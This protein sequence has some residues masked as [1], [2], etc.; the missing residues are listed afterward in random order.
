MLILLLYIFTVFTIQC[1]YNVCNNNVLIFFNFVLLFI[2]LWMH[3]CVFL[4]FVV[5]GMYNVR[6]FKFITCI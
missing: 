1:L 4:D 6:F 2:C 5:L 3:I